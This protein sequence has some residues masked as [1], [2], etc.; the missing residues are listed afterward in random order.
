M[1]TAIISFEVQYD[2]TKTDSDA[3]TCALEV[4]LETGL[5]TPGILEEYGTVEV[6]PFG[7]KDE[8]TECAA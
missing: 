4:V 5:S 3:I 6:G 1:K 8:D 7:V 2:E